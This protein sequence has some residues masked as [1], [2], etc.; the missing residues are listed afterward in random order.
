MHREARVLKS[1]RKKR[2]N[3]LLF[4]TAALLAVIMV[5]VLSACTEQIDPEQEIIQ[6]GYIHE[7]TYDAN[8]G[9]FNSDFNSPAQYEYVRVQENSLTIEPEYSADNEEGDPNSITLYRSGISNNYFLAGWKLVLFDEEGNETGLSEEYWNFTTDRVTGDITLR[10]DWVQRGELVLNITV[11]DQVVTFNQQTSLV[12]TPGESFLSSLYSANSSN[13]YTVREDYVRSSVRSQTTEDD[14]TYT[15]LEFFYDED[16]TQPVTAENAVY[17][18]DNRPQLNLYARY[19]EGNFN[20]LS[21]ETLSAGT[22]LTSSS[23]WYLVTD[24]DFS[25]RSG[26]AVRW[27]ALRLFSGTIYGNGHSITGVEIRSE[28]NDDRSAPASRSI[29]GVMQGSVRDLTF[30]GVQFTV[31]AQAITDTGR[32]AIEIAFL[33]SSFSGGVFDNVTLTDCTVRTINATLENENRGFTYS[34]TEG[35]T[36]ENWLAGSNSGTVTGNA[37]FVGHLQDPT[38]GLFD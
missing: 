36:V 2:R 25:D 15:L 23:N 21:Q 38:Y 31:Y 14:Q 5:G 27:D 24:L 10:A 37:T 20:V 29:F 13:G 6:A 30:A 34:L 1:M 26:T 7:V 22:S 16:L 28:V 11:D 19:L 3:L 9:S 32:P 4:L 12:V 18:E 33:A 17:P 8:G 35:E